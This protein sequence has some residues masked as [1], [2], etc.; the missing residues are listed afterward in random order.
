MRA[1]TVKE[2]DEAI[3]RCHPNAG[4]LVVDCQ[5]KQGQPIQLAY[6]PRDE[7]ADEDVMDQFI[8]LNP[9]PVD[10]PRPRDEWDGV[11]GSGARKLYE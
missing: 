11:V 1:P 3:A 5:G 6:R 4:V 8:M 2:I 10:D 7:N 9:P